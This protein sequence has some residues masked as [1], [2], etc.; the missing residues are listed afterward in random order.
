MLNLKTLVKKL[1][2]VLTKEKPKKQ[3]LTE[4]EKEYIM[5]LMDK[6]PKE[7]RKYH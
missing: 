6:V 4:K 5:L 2:S 1:K 3:R 7:N